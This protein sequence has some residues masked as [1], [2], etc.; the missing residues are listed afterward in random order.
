MQIKVTCIEIMDHTLYPHQR[1]VHFPLYYMC[2]CAHT[3]SF[4]IRKCV[5]GIE[6]KVEKG[7]RIYSLIWNVQVQS[8]HSD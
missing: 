1:E 3:F 8:S 6:R 2:F 5:R 7:A 4:V